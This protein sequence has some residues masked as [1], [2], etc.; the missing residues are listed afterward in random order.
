MGERDTSLRIARATSKRIRALVG[1]HYAIQTLTLR[2][3]VT[4]FFD[5]RER[6][7][8]E[9]VEHGFEGA[10]KKIGRKTA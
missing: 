3:T 2:L 1:V 9:A 6:R 4:G 10:L 5:S 8:R 7:E